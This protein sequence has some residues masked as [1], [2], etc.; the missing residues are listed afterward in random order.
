MNL[1]FNKIEVNIIWKIHLE[2]VLKWIVKTNL[3]TFGY[4]LSLLTLL[5]AG[6]WYNFTACV[7]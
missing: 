5:K 6:R 2:F 1:L 7:L 3:L 4:Q